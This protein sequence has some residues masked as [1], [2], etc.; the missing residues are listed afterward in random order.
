[1]KDQRMIVR[2]WQRGLLTMALIAAISSAAGVRLLG[3]PVLFLQ[4][5]DSNDDKVKG[6]TAPDFQLKTVDGVT[7]HLADLRGKTVVVNFWASWCEPCLDEMPTLA[8][9]QKKYGDKG[10]QI[11]GISTEKEDPATV[12]ELSARMKLNYPLLEGQDEIGA[13]YGG[14]DVL[15]TTFFI[16]R[17][18]KFIDRTVGFKPPQTLESLVRSALSLR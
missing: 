10:L 12:R 13:A 4:S 15:P 16:D 5:G 6:L 9:L 2:S 18:G 11:V 3:A 1:M 7:I 14:I 8:R 17:E